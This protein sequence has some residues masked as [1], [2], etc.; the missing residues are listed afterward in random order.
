MRLYW[1]LVKLAFQ[2]QMTYRTANLAG[3][4]TNVFFGFLRAAVMVALYGSRE[5]VTGMQLQAAIT[6]TGLSQAVIGYL[7]VF[8]WYELM[9]SVYS[10]EVG[11]DLLKPLR[12][13]WL[14]LA[15]DIG[16]AAGSFLMRSIPIMVVYA[17]IFD[18]VFPKSTI[19]WLAL[20]ASMILGLLVGF[21]FRFLVNL[22]S[23][24]TPN[25]VGI[26]RMAFGLVWILSGFFMPLRFFPEWFISIAR[27]TPFPAM[28]N[29]IVEIYLGLLSGPQL[30]WALLEQIMWLGLLFI[31]SEI[32]LRAGVKRLVI[33]G[34]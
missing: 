27:L 19:Q 18:I 7:S 11:S 34:G 12:L 16:R 2:R 31:L 26:G 6:Y 13:F 24:W 17:V 29:T 28:V 5:E 32:L 8:G 4:A 33:Q 3:L 23:F 9:N 30:M 10:G 15:R 1:E 21:A 14:W 25:A 20:V 22:A